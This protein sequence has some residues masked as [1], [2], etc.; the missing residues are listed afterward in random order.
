MKFCKYHGLGNDFIIISN[1]ESNMLM[2]AKNAEKLCHRHFGIG[3]DGVILVEQSSVADIRMIIYN[4]DGSRPEMCGNGLRCFAKFVYDEGIVKKSIIVVETDAGIMNVEIKSDE[5]GASAVVVNMGGPEFSAEKVPVIINKSEAINCEI[6]IEGSKFNITSM[7]MGVPHTVVF[8]DSLEDEA[9]MRLGKLI[10]NSEYFPYK[11]NV[12]F[13][14]VLNRENVILRT[15]ERGAGYTYACGTGACAS[16]AAAIV[17]NLTDQT[18]KVQLRGGD[19]V[20]HW[21]DRG[22]IFMEGPAT[23]VFEGIYTDY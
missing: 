7:L 9:V 5:E 15:W 22:D 8:V 16:V 19:L 23:K 11:T 3:A 13:V 1:M 14:K 2:D 4:S 18:V 21:K 17:N 20:I 6:D 12:N 10:E